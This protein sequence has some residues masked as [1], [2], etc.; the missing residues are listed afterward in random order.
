MNTISQTAM[1]GLQ[2]AYQG[3]HRN[4][5]AIAKHQP[6]QNGRSLSQSLVEL[7]QHEQAAKANV[8]TL[9]TADDMIGSLLDT[10]A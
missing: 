2:R 9:K 4:A 10:F 5:E 8:Q 7:Q 6:N 3:L 1:Q